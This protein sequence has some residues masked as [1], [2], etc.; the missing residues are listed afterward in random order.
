MGAL[1]W[2]TASVIII[3]LI[4]I[5]DSSHDYLGSN[6]GNVYPLCDPGTY[7][8]VCSGKDVSTLIQFLSRVLSINS[9]NIMLHAT[10]MNIID[11]L[12]I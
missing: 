4:L 6:I 7:T 5:N 8:I 12:F 2:I 9:F 1:R 11:P 3:Y 10:K